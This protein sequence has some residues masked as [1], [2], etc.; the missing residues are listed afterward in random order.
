MTPYALMQTDRENWNR[1]FA[2][3]SHASPAPD[4]FFVQAHQEYIAP[5]LEAQAARLVGRPDAPAIGG[6]LQ[7]LD[8]AAGAGRHGLWLAERGWR[9]TMVDI[10]DE[11][12]AL[13]QRRAR[14]RNVEVEF[15]QRDLDDVRSAKT[16]GWTG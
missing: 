13:A 9:V 11:G 1:R 14:G 12:L 16:E 2:E 4:D 6:S 7:A 15:L 3:G 10:A 5:L 8:V